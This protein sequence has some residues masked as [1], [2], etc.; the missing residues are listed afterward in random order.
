MGLPLLHCNSD[1]VKEKFLKKDL[2][3][4]EAQSTGRRVKPG[5]SKV[6]EAATGTHRTVAYYLNPARFV[7]TVRLRVVLVRVRHDVIMIASTMM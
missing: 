1:Y 2:R 6:D 4:M 7:D 5:E 3:Q